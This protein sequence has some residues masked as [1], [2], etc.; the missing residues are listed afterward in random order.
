M[1]GN[2]GAHMFL[3][4]RALPKGFAFGYG[5]SLVAMRGRGP[6]D[7]DR[8]VAFESAEAASEFIASLP[9]P[10]V[11]YSLANSVS[12]GLDA[13]IRPN[14][15]ALVFGSIDQLQTYRA[16]SAAHAVPAAMPLARRFSWGTREFKDWYA[17]RQAAGAYA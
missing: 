6:A 9:A 5:W 1:K 16:G 17:A 10:L 14:A 12:L 7:E 8:Y 13:Y 3:V 4:R 2:C 11:A 15:G